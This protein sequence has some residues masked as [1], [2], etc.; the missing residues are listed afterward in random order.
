MLKIFRSCPFCLK[1]CAYL[2]THKQPW[3]HYPDRIHTCTYMMLN[4][5]KGQNCSFWTHAFSHFFRNSSHLSFD[6]EMAFNSQRCFISVFDDNTD[7]QCPS[8]GCRWWKRLHSLSKFPQKGGGRLHNILVVILILWQTVKCSSNSLTLSATEVA[9]AVTA[10]TSAHFSA[11]WQLQCYPHKQWVLPSLLFGLQGQRW[12][13]EIKLW[14]HIFRQ[15]QMLSVSAFNM[16]ARFV[17]QLSYFQRCSCQPSPDMG[18]LWW[19]IH[20]LF[21]FLYSSEPHFIVDWMFSSKHCSVSWW[22]LRWTTEAVCWSYWPSESSLSHL[23]EYC[24]SCLTSYYKNTVSVSRLAKLSWQVY[25]HLLL[26]NL[27]T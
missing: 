11:H 12:L 14:N 17:M 16:T 18:F 1:S 4:M 26:F 27:S 10:W 22:Q 5:Q 19:R 23:L 6:V 15:D 9:V 25:F 8:P 21:F 13:S 20:P 2:F 7:G 3:G 24:Y